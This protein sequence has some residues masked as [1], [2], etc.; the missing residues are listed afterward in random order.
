MTVIKLWRNIIIQNKNFIY[1]NHSNGLY[2][3]HPSDP[4]FSG[5]TKVAALNG[6]NNKFC[7]SKRYAIFYVDN[8]QKELY[9]SSKESVSTFLE[10]HCTII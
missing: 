5:V 7:A 1:I 3:L 4:K 8:G 10:K 2:R 6:Y 9:Q